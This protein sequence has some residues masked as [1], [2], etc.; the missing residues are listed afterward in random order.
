[1][2]TD[3]TGLYPSTSAMQLA[4]TPQSNRVSNVDQIMVKA[5]ENS[6]PTAMKQINEVIRER[7]RI[8]PG[9]PDDFNI[10]DNTEAQNS[11][12]SMVRVVSSLLLF[13]AAISLVVGG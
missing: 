7:H 2:T 8:R 1:P 5:R 11:Y 12:S 10:R 13:A 6:V 3:T 4:D 9:Q